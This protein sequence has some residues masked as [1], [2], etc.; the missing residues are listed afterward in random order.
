M[1]S[2]AFAHRGLRA[3][4]K[5]MRNQHGVALLAVLMVMGLVIIMGLGS[6]TIS[7]WGNKLAAYSRT[8]ETSAQAA[9]ACISTAV[10]I[11]QDTIDEGVMPV[12]Y[13]DTAVPAGPVPAVTAV[14]LQQEIIGQFDNSPD[15]ALAMPNT[16]VLLNGYTVSGDID[17][18]Y[19]RPKAGS[20][21]QFAGGYEGVAGGAAAGGVDI[22]YRI[23]CTAQHAATATM[24]R[25]TAVYA[26]TLAGDTCQ[27]QP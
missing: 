20:A 27:R 6:L 4:G 14:S 11:I 9:E 5:N 26:C 18:L 10:K 21:M 15:A 24:T 17:R 13:L 8:T 12:S 16:R 23:D 7:G 2:T 25:I 22:Y 19:A 1:F 3:G